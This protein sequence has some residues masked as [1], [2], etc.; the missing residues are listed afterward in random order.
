M[1]IYYHV[2]QYKLNTYKYNR[3]LSSQTVTFLFDLSKKND[4]FNDL[5]NH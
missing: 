1:N 2:I 3:L 4:F 5:I